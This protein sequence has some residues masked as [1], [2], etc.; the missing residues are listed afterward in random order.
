MLYEHLNIT[1]PPMI[2]EPDLTRRAST[3]EGLFAAAAEERGSLIAKL[4]GAGALLFRGFP[5]LTIAEFARFARDLAGRQL[6]HYV[7]GASPRTQLGGGVYTST[8]YPSG[9]TI[10]LHN[11]LSYTFEWPE[12][13]FFYCVTPPAAGGET[14]PPTAARS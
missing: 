3:A 11:E 9:I 1:K 8:E 12:Y 2:V 13:L 10:P 7:A 4:R 14:P 5:K 6:L